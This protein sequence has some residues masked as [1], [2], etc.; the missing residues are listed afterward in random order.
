MTMKKDERMRFIGPAGVLA[1]A[2]KHRSPDATR[3]TP[4]VIA[5]EIN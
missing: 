2:C 1:T 4:T 3:E 5:V